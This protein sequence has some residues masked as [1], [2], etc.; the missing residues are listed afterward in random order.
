MR[1]R[2]RDKDIEKRVGGEAEREELSR[3]IITNLVDAAV[4]CWSFTLFGGTGPTKH[5]V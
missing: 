4:F 2:E 1:E 3:K 5:K